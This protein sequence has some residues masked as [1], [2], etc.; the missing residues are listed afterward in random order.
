[1]FYLLVIYKNELK[2]KPNL[3]IASKA[4][5]S[6]NEGWDEV[7]CSDRIYC[8]LRRTHV[9]YK[10]ILRDLLVVELILTHFTTKSVFQHMLRC[11]HEDNTKK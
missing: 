9:I 3:Q 10:L 2:N 7:F 6:K 1:M 11:E 4:V 5:K 8:E